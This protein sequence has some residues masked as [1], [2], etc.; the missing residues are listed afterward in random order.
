MNWLTSIKTLGD[1]IKRNFIKKFPSKEEIENSKWQAKNCCN[2]GTSPKRRSYKKIIINVPIVL[3][4]S[5]LPPSERFWIYVW[6]K[7]IMKYLD[8]PMFNDPSL[9]SLGRCHQASIKIN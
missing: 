9:L 1:K 4:L 2:S 7:S 6:K 8:T 5:H 3:L